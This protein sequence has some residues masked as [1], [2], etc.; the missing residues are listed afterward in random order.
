LLP[1]RSGK[2]SSI[3]PSNFAG[4][5]TSL[6]CDERDPKTV[7][8]GSA[9]GGV[10]RSGDAGKTWEPLWDDRGMYPVLSVG[11]LAITKDTEGV[12]LYAGT[13]EANLSSDN[14]PGNGIWK[15]KDG[16]GV[17]WDQLPQS[18]DIPKRI[19]TIAIDPDNNGRILV[20]G[21]CHSDEQPCGMFVFDDGIW[22]RKQDL[23]DLILGNYYCHSIL[24]HP[25][26]KVI[27]T[28][29][30]ARGS[31]SG[32][33]RKRSTGGWEHLTNGLP[34]GDQF[35]RTS[36]AVSRSHSNVIY[37]LAADRT[38]GVL[39]VFR[40]EDEGEHWNE[41]GRGRF[42]YE[43]QMSYN[44][45]IA[46][47]PEDPDFVI[48][49]GIDLYL[50]NDGGNTW[51]KVTKSKL[52][53]RA[54]RSPRYVHQDH[55]ALLIVQRSQESKERAVFLGK[56]GEVVGAASVSI[57]QDI[58]IYDGNDGGVSIS[59]DGGNTWEDRSNGLATTMF[60][61]VDVAQGDSK[62][63]N[64]AGGTQ[65]NGTLMT[66]RAQL[67][68]D[69]L[70]EK[71]ASGL[72]GQSPKEPSNYVCK[73]SRKL[74]GDGGWVVYDPT[75]AAHFYVSTQRMHLYRRRVGADLRD[76]T[77]AGVTAD[78]RAGIWMSFIDMDPVEARTVFTASDRVWRTLDDGYSWRASRSLDDS[79]VSA[80]EVS[81]QNRRRI[82][83]GTE[84]GGLFRSLDGGDTWSQNLAGAVLPG[85]II[86]RI[87]AHPD[88]EDIVYVTVGSVG[89][90]RSFQGPDDPPKWSVGQA[91]SDKLIPFSHVFRSTDG[92]ETWEDA[93]PFRTL[94]DVPH[95]AL[96][97]ETNAPYRLFVA[98]DVS[99][100]MLA[101]TGKWR[102]YSDN[103]PSV[104]VTDLVYHKVTKTLTAA[105]Y[106]RGLWSRYV[107]PPAPIKE[108]G[109]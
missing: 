2:W 54:T 44:N 30:D 39:G 45:C 78:E 73:F 22:T 65:D 29:I 70:A 26:T 109:E 13:G 80:I 55:H 41:I 85:R 61:D 12:L 58:L 6:V 59:E 89:M 32:I 24:V 88:D 48:W 28:A 19:G 82:Y 10:W 102:D 37:A 75:D 50:T 90:Q 91:P 9:G 104:T 1:D 67:P 40:S 4:R 35:A 20:G 43:G 77:P 84:K 79:P 11:A 7:F 63:R 21:V 101:E 62:G 49:G 107:S 72:G 3:G 5:I 97:F 46:V 60:Y 14:Y 18:R 56:A 76:V 53:T 15:S 25:Q 31:Q 36:I 47:H 105:T 81:T 71:A 94:P 99:I 51:T 34:P 100:Y 33:W 68:K 86:T 92:G 57:K 98:G 8:A 96:S 64:V 38:G 52:S 17:H 23:D 95:L 27:F 16:K 93:D 83:A 69:P 74:G 108:G 87:G 66:D 103:L 106:G 42:R